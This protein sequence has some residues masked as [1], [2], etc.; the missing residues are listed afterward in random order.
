MMA[1]IH[2]SDCLMTHYIVSV[3]AAQGR[4]CQL[5]MC[6]VSFAGQQMRQ[7]HGKHRCMHLGV[8]DEASEQLHAVHRRVQADGT[9]QLH[10]I[11]DLQVNNGP[12]GPEE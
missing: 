4:C 7:Q 8:G 6:K 5:I 9:R 3:H 12:G 1:V 11:L 10:H 2:G